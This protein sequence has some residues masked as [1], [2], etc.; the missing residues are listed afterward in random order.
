MC[1]SVSPKGINV[2]SIINIIFSL[3]LSFESY[4]L[5]VTSLLMLV[6]SLLVLAFTLQPFAFLL[7]HN[8][9]YEKINLEIHLLNT[10]KE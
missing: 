2:I 4:K 8:Q 3:P 7:S 9:H 10:A 1:V 6:Y 5:S